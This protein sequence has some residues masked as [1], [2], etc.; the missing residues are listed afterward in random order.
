MLA[1]PV[2]DVD[3]YCLGPQNAK[4]FSYNAYWVIC[5]RGFEA[6]DDLAPARDD[7]DDDD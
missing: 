3:D 4:G 5:N 7:D 6:L 2:V 1:C